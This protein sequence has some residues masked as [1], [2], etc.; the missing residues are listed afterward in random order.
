MSTRPTASNGTSKS[1]G[2]TAAGRAA[3]RSDGATRQAAAARPRAGT[4]GRSAPPELVEGPDVAGLLPAPPLTRGA[5]L[6]DGVKGAGSVVTGVISEHPLP[7]ALIGAGISWLLLERRVTSGVAALSR[8]V[9]ESG[10]MERAREAFE[11]A[12]ERATA[13]AGSLSDALAARVR[14]AGETFAEA[15]ESLRER[16]ARVGE[17]TVEG[18][19]AAGARLRQGATVVGESARRGLEYGRESAAGAWEQHP[20]V[21]G[22]AALTAGVAVGLLLP[23]TRREN[24][25]MGRQSD[26]LS[27][28]IRTAGGT[29]IERGRK[30]ASTAAEALRQEAE[31]EGLGPQEVVRKVRRIADHVQEATRT[32]ARRERLDPA[33]VISE[34]RDAAPEDLDVAGDGRKTRHRNP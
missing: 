26:A 33:S 8:H 10:V 28:R 4:A 2:R 30:V 27:R 5:R 6:I 23:G 9:E 14:E 18:A 13:A 3:R 24:D 15:A 31:G 22:L 29:L 32:A 12:S 7:V 16:A 20:L 21:T 25:I 19:Q 17:S 1:K 11:D 34:A